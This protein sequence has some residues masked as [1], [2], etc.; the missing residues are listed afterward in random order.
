[1]HEALET[2]YALRIMAWCRQDKMAM[3]QINRDIESLK[4]DMRGLV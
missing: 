3:R 1:M 2:L 4:N